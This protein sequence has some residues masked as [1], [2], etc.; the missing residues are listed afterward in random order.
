[1]NKI[2]V[3][4]RSSS[5]DFAPPRLAVNS[6]TSDNLNSMSN[7]ALSTSISSA[8]NSLQIGTGIQ[9]R[10][11]LS[12]VH[13]SHPSDYPGASEVDVSKGIKD[14]SNL[15]DTA[16]NTDTS[17]IDDYFEIV[18]PT[19]PTVAQDSSKGSLAKKPVQGTKLGSPDEQMF[20]RIKVLPVRPASSA[21]TAKLASSNTSSNPFSELYA[22]ISGRAETASMEVI[23]FFPHATKPANKPLKLNVRKDATVEETIGFALWSYWEDGWLPKLDEGI[24]D[25]QKKTRLSAVGWVLRIAED[26]G[27]VDEDF[28]GNLRLLLRRAS[29]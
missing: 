28:P 7:S 5:S 18:Q 12:P 11:K 20:K 8:Y 29:C 13:E 1:M 2:L 27:E 23:V 16:S 25:E 21:L 26:D 24:S 3:T 19:R 17:T 15:T 9:N 4:H 14:N 6:D 10:G 22:L